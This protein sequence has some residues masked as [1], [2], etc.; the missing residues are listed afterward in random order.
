MA[1]IKVDYKDYFIKTMEQMCETGLLLVTQG[2][3]HKANIMTIGWGTIGSIWGK[4]PSGTEILRES[5]AII[6]VLHSRTEC[7]EFC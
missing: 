3:D 2:K 4:V 7:T 6:A 5:R 1:K